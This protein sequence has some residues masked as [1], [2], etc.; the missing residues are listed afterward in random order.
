MILLYT[1]IIE[2]E[3][4]GI[5]ILVSFTGEVYSDVI[6]VASEDD[7]SLFARAQVVCTLLA[8]VH[9]HRIYTLH[10]TKYNNN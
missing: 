1:F 9:P 10:Q 4:L 5:E 7:A 2:P 8:I 3:S 6:S